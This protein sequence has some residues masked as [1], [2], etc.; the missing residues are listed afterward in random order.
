[1][2]KFSRGST[3]TNKA[4]PN[5]VDYDELVVTHRW[6][7]LDTGAARFEF[8]LIEHESGNAWETEFKER[9]LSN[10]GTFIKEYNLQF[11]GYTPL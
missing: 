10:L 5:D 8:V 11:V 4:H 7:D 9:T 3:Y 1:M 2:N 6:L